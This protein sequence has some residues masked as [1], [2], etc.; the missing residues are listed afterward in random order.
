[1]GGRGKTLGNSYRQVKL[2]E[3]EEHLKIEKI[4]N[5]S[6]KIRSKGFGGT[7]RNGVIPLKKCACC[8]EYTILVNQHHTECNVCGWID[9][10]L[11]NA[12]PDSEGGMNP[13][14][15]SEAKYNWEN[16]RRI[17]V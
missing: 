8:E 12:N 4:I 16:Y 5:E 9:D 17:I 6:D 13:I 11:Q 2:H 15:L 1:M 10:P 7:G 3:Y 14:C